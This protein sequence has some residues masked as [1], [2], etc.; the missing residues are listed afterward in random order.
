MPSSS[1]WATLIPTRCA[2]IA[3]PA[4]VRWRRSL[5]RPRGRS[6]RDLRHGEQLEDLLAVLDPGS[7]PDQLEDLLPSLHLAHEDRADELVL[8]EEEPLVVALVVVDLD[9]CL[10]G[11]LLLRGHPHH[12]DV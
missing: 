7:T 2:G 9:Q 11:R 8:E 6:R 4:R 5:L 3:R 12:G 10:R 1:P